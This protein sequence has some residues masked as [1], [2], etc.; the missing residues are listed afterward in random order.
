MRLLTFTVL[1]TSI[2]LVAA[3]P[4]PPQDGI[5]TLA[6]RHSNSGKDISA[7]QNIEPLTPPKIE[8]R[9]LVKGADYGYGE[10]D[11]DEEDEEIKQGKE[12]TSLEQQVKD[13]KKKIQKQSEVR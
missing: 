4:F 3:A 8:S 12:I 7:D 10:N 11:D 13:L 6:T 1:C 5:N 2:T 9:V